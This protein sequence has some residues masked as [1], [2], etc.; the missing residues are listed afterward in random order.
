VHARPPGRGR[1]LALAAPLVVVLGAWN[2]VVVTRLPGYPG[3]YVPANV[4]AT[5]L[6]LVAARAAGLSWGDMGLD[7]RRLRA[8][9][10]WGGGCAAVVGAGCAAGLAIPATRPLFADARLA[11]A[12]GGEVAYQVVVRIPLGTVLWEETAFRGVLL[13]ALAPLLSP[14]AAIGGSAVVFGVWHVRPTLSALAAN[15][16]AEGPVARWSALLLGCG[17]AA[18]AGVLFAWL[19]VRSGSLLAPLLLHLATNTLGTLAAAAAHRLGEGRRVP[20]RGR[21]VG[22]L[23][24]GKRSPRRRTPSAAVLDRDGTGSG[25]PGAPER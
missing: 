9:L 14:P 15:G 10:R 8:G 18:A 23:T 12:S 7:R 3:S 20:N 1:A 19:R 2:N 24:G 6:V 5:G 11:G 17:T 13:A 22:G 16:L 21:R 4:M 25:H